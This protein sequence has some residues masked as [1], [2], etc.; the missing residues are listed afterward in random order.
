MT[1]QMMA[2]RIALVLGIGLTLLVRTEAQTAEEV[3]ALLGEKGA[4]KDS[5]A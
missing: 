3:L 1:V 4:D 5:L 2:W